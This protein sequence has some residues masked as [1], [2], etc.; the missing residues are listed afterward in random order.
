[1][2]FSELPIEWQEEIK[3]LRTESASKRVKWQA[4]LSD[5]RAECA[6]YRTQLR[7]AQARIT[8]LE[9]TND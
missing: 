8:E 1:M 7:A 3:R 2:E 4:K 9:N 6:K 5:L